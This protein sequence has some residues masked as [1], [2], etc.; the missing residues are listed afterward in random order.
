MLTLSMV[1]PVPRKL[2]S[3]PCELHAIFFNVLK[4]RVESH[5]LKVKYLT[6]LCPFQC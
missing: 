3:H 2:S 4:F 5:P 6:Y 1:H